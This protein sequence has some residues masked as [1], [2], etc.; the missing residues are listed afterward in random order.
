MPLQIGAVID[1]S[2]IS[3]DKAGSFGSLE[4]AALSLTMIFVAPWIAKWTPRRV[5]L[6][7]CALAFLGSLLLCLVGSFVGELIAGLLA[8]IGSGLVFAATIAGGVGAAEP[9]RFYAIGN[10]VALLVVFSVLSIVPS[11]RLLAGPAGVFV[12]MAT[13]AC[14][15]APFMGGFG[16]PVQSQRLR[17]KLGTL[18][19]PG[20][21]GLLFAWVTFSM[22]TQGLYAFSER[23]GRSNHLPDGQIAYVLSVGLFVGLLG[24]GAAIALGS[25]ISRRLA[26]GA[27][28]LGSAASCLLLGFSTTIAMFAAGI[29]LYWICYM[30]L[31]SY[32]LGT[33]AQLE[34]SGRLGALGGGLERL[35][36][37]AGVWLAGLLAEHVSY[38]S[39]GVMACIACLAGL[40]IGMPSVFRALRPAI[41]PVGG[42]VNTLKA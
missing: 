31:Y 32:L 6:V 28:L 35:G 10:S 24:T 20:A 27:G 11:V 33:A 23:I 25:K 29:F 34:P 16:A 21:L 7:G 12:C 4:I 9:D 26:L 38:A 41:R 18:R 22:G 36:Y 15:S 17:G 2:H 3:A 37:A 42:S 8:G 30:F 13:L 19:T 39:T 40:F 14:V 1:R 5:A